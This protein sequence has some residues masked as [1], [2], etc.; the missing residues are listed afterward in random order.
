M[1]CTLWTRLV[2]R[3]APRREHTGATV[4]PSFTIQAHHSAATATQDKSTNITHHINSSTTAYL[5][6][7]MMVGPGLVDEEAQERVARDVSD[8]ER[9]RKKVKVGPVEQ[10]TSCGICWQVIESEVR[11][12]LPAVRCCD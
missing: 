3:R 5:P 2:H 9:P 6:R 12:P 8:R 11:E 1:A 7:D 10:Q 4:T